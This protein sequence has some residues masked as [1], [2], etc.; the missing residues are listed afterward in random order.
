MFDLLVTLYSIWI[1]ELLFFIVIAALSLNHPSTVNYKFL[2]Y[3]LIMFIS[4]SGLH[5]IIYLDLAD[6]PLNFFSLALIGYMAIHLALHPRLERNNIFLD[7]STEIAMAN[8]ILILTLIAY[9]ILFVIFAIWGLILIRKELKPLF[10]KPLSL[11][12]LKISSWTIV[13]LIGLE[14]PLYYQV[15]DTETLYFLF[16]VLNAFILIGLFKTYQ[17]K[18]ALPITITEKIDLKDLE[19]TLKDEAT[20]SVESRLVGLFDKPKDNK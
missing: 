18:K 8:F 19:Q 14:I 15:L 1:V 2:F 12:N 16:V 10:E 5:L 20:K 17:Y 11:G 4:L 6:D 13:Y 3:P 9:D 7:R